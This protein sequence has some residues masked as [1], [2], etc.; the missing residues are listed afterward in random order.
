MPLI[1]S[2]PESSWANCD[3]F[4]NKFQKY[5]ANQGLANIKVGASGGITENYW[6]DI[7]CYWYSTGGYPESN[8]ATFRGKNGNDHF[9]ICKFGADSGRYIHGVT[10]LKFRED[11]DST[12]G[13][14]IY[15]FRYGVEIVSS[16]GSY[17]LYDLSGKMSRPGSYGK[18]H[19]KTFNSTLKNRLTSSWYISK[20]ILEISCAGGSG[21]RTTQT[22]IKQLQFKTPQ[23]PASGSWNLILPPKRGW[24]ARNDQQR[25]G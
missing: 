12:A 5:E 18:W 14:G 2:V 3:T 10:G 24:S 23:C 15:V 17:E 9:A 11:N 8:G 20:L 1:Y 22:T 7:D 21:T 19:E 13:H 6:G 25:I 4:G 16:S